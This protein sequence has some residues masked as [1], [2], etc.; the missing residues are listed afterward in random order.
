MNLSEH[1]DTQL[2]RL[3]SLDP[4]EDR[5]LELDVEGGRLEIRL[6]AVDQL[7]CSFERLVLHIEPPCELTIEGLLGVAEMLR[8][9]LTY[10]L[11]AVTP[12]E[13]DRKAGVVQMRSAPP[14]KDDRGTRYYEVVVRNGGI[15]LCRYQKPPDQDRRIAPTTVTREVLCRL[16]E[17]FVA[18]A[19][20]CRV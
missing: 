19:G 8:D 4:N 17:D 20:T 3:A 14:T 5:R 15:H 7:A 16:A 11:E 12:L 6:T 9:R 13:T 10:L 1:I 2:T 18:S